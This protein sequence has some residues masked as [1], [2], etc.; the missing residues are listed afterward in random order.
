MKAI[1]RNLLIHSAKAYSEQTEDTW[2]DKSR[3]LIAEL[4][5]V[6]IEPSA[7]IRLTNTNEQVQLSA[8]LFFDCRNSAPKDFDF[9]KTDII[10]ACGSEYRVISVDKLYDERGLHHYEVGLCL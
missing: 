1:P 4:D 10:T 8:V 3:E 2:N 9:S 5:L 6:R 7:S